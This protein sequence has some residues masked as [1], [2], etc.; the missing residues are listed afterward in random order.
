[1]IDCFRAARVSKRISL[2][3][4][5]TTS[6]GKHKTV[7][8]NHRYGPIPDGTMCILPREIVICFGVISTLL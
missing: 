4:C 8:R 7:S 2:A 6:V 3:A 1:M 5:W